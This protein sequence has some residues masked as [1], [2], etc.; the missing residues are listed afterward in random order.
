MAA[1]VPSTGVVAT[2]PSWKRATVPFANELAGGTA[3]AGPD[4]VALALAVGVAVAVPLALAL[5]VA[6]AVGGWRCRPKADWLIDVVCELLDTAMKIPRPKPSAT[7][8]AR[9]TA[10]RAVRLRRLRRLVTDRCPVSIQS[11]SMSSVT[12]RGITLDQLGAGIHGIGNILGEPL[13]ATFLR[14]ILRTPNAADGA[15]EIA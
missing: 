10:T 12:L 5:G 4:A 13:Q 3:A 1:P 6:D 8:M 15:L 14:K 2:S 9:G 7:G 11:T